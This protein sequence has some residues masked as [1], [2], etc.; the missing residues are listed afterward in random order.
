ME[1]EQAAVPRC[2]TES[3][4]LVRE[5]YLLLDMPSVSEMQE[6]PIPGE[7]ADALVDSA[8]RSGGALDW[9][10]KV[11]NGPITSCLAWMA[12]RRAA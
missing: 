4:A 8:I 7:F 3:S 11:R 10:R 5:Q 2:L 9:I 12:D 6:R 1:D